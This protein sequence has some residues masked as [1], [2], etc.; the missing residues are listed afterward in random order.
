MKVIDLR[1]NE[2]KSSGENLNK[3]KAR[4]AEGK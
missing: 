1:S 3:I 2:K 4:I